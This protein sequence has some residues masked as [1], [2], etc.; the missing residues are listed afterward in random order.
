MEHMFFRHIDWDKLERL[1]VQPPWRPVIV[2]DSVALLV[3]L[4]NRMTH[5]SSMVWTYMYVCHG[6]E[7]S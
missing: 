7:C 1:E 6:R 3:L 2:S 4:I 5:T